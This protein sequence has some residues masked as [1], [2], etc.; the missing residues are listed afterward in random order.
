[1]TTTQGI[2]LD[3]KTRNRL[4]ALAE[5]RNRSPHWIMKT[6]IVSYLEHEE[7]Y[8]REK[9]EDMERW[10]QYQLTGKSVDQESVERLLD[11]LS[12]NKE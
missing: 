3:D 8:E 4:K 12:E 1:M 11:K 6:A 9:S 2:K 10:E 7:S 5:K